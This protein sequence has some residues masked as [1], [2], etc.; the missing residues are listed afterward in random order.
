MKIPKTNCRSYLLLLVI[1]IC[2]LGCSSDDST[3]N[4][5]DNGGG[6]AVTNYDITA[7]LSKF[8]SAGMSYEINGDNVIFTTNDLPDHKS[9]YYLDTEWEIE[10]Y[11]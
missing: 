6:I 5:S 11:Y 1:L 8:N 7:I 3:S 9:P 2:M 10:L 4:P